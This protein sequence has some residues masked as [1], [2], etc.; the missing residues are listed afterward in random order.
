MYCIDNLWEKEIKGKSIKA[1][2]QSSEIRDI[3]SMLET[4]N[5]P[6]EISPPYPHEIP[7]LSSIYKQITTEE[8]NALN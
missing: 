8:M 2:G 3:L 1:R 4:Y 7:D 6:Y 5:I